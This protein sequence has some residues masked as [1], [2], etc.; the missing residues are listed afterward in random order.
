MAYTTENIVREESPF[1]DDQLVE[2]SYVVRAISQA[3]DFID[4]RISSVY[5]LPLDSTPSLI[6]HCSTTLAIYYLIQDQNLNFEIS[7]GVDISTAVN[8]SLAKLTMIADRQLKLLD[9]AGEELETV[10]LIKPTGYPTNT[11]TDDGTAV[12]HFT[13]NQSF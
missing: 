11:T 9:S 2:S 6:Q 8:D 4:A 5:L 3:D 1:K 13:S 7:S 12:R 10:S